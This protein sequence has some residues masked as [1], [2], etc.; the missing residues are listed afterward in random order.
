[1]QSLCIQCKAD[2]R[3]KSKHSNLLNI[4]SYLLPTHLYHI[5]CNACEECYRNEEKDSFPPLR[6][7]L[8]LANKNTTSAFSLQTN[9]LLR[10][11]TLVLFLSGS[12]RSR[13][14]WRGTAC[15]HQWLCVS[16]NPFP[17]LSNCEHLPYLAGVFRSSRREILHRLYYV[18]PLYILFYHW[19]LENLFGS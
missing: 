1:M 5:I 6:S 12:R 16:L 2:H 10:G 7:S 17:P 18:R 19:K 9:V 11:D 4:S 14:F 15:F 13:I 8:T 3:N